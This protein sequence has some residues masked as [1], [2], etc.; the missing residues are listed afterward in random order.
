MNLDS[1]ISNKIECELHSGNFKIFF[2]WGGA[3]GVVHHMVYI[4]TEKD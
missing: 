2:G 4:I 3:G 1:E